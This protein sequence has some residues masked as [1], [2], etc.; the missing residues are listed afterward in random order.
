MKQIQYP[1]LVLLFFAFSAYADAQKIVAP[2]SV[3]ELFDKIT[4]LEIKVERFTNAKQRANVALELSLLNK[5]VTEHSLLTPSIEAL[6]AEL[7]E[8]NKKLWDIEDNIRAQ[9]AKK[10]F[11]TEFIK[12]ARSVY[13]T[14]DERCQIK[15]NINIQAGSQLI[16]EKQY[17][18][19]A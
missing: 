3:G 5:T 15:R 18:T 4:I 6:K 17:R 19:Y 14:N 2:V 10:T 12:L 1:S 16:E 11:D 7:L 13:F 9:E 8:V